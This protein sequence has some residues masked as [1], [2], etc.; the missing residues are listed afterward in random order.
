MKNDL[1]IICLGG[2]ESKIPIISA[3]KKQNFLCCVV[4]KNKNCSA[5]K[6]SDFFINQSIS[7]YEQ[8]LEELQKKNISKKT[9][10][11]FSYVS[12]KSGQFTGQYLSSV[13][14]TPF[15]EKSILE[16]SWD[17]MKLKQFC[18]DH[19][20]LTPSLIT[21]DNIHEKKIIHKP[22]SSIGSEGVSLH[23]S[24]PTQKNNSDLVFEE[25]L[26]NQIFI[27]QGMIVN[28]KPVMFFVLKKHIRENTFT[29]SGYSTFKD[30]KLKDDLIKITQNF[31][32][33][34]GL[35]N[36]FFGF[37]FVYNEKKLFLIDFGILLDS[38]I[39]ILLEHFGMNI[40]ENFL[41]S[42]H[43]THHE[44]IDI[45]EKMSMMLLYSHQ[46]GVITRLPL[47][48][49]STTSLKYIKSVGDSCVRGTV[50]ADTIGYVASDSN[51]DDLSDIG[52]SIE[53]EILIDIN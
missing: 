27:C 12:D 30:D 22:R 48:N 35:D 41:E 28:K 15:V 32:E 39:H 19:N 38:G 49:S 2:S 29:I 50:V 44:M 21:S 26:G 47:L 8:I 5:K 25:Y 31:I 1:W 53:K 7:N 33:V 37:E 36:S 4:D 45:P 16:L 10:L 9:I 23:D 34:S 40:F 24:F 52:K 20:F 6:F 11:V 13:L 14:K 3:I 17:K 42:L 46:K 51:W 18:I 43:S